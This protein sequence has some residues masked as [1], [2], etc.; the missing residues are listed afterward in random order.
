MVGFGGVFVA[1]STV[2]SVCVVA[3]RLVVF[4][5]SISVGFIFLM[6]RRPD[7]ILVYDWTLGRSSTT[8]VKLFY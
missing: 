8:A 7:E 3:F 4:A 6:K 1:H 2:D 5:N